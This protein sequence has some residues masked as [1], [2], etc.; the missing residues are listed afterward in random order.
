MLVPLVVGPPHVGSLDSG[1]QP[2]GCK[3]QQAIMAISAT[4]HRFSG[5]PVPLAR[6]CSVLWVGLAP[7]IA[8]AD[9]TWFRIFA[10]LRLD[11]RSTCHVPGNPAADP[12]HAYSSKQSKPNLFDENAQAILLARGGTALSS[13]LCKEYE[14]CL[15]S[16]RAQTQNVPI[17]RKSVLPRAPSDRTR[18]RHAQGSCAAV[19]RSLGIDS[20]DSLSA[21]LEQLLMVRRCINELFGCCCNTSFPVALCRII[22]FWGSI[23]Q[24]HKHHKLSRCKQF[25][26]GKL[27]RSA[28]N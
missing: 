2:K 16:A 8:T 26:N 17:P 19:L 1:S 25:K 20:L 22:S 18:S 6:Q 27:Q 5:L 28:T 14:P 7:C 13:R 4:G 23:H 24:K 3:A 9:F 11:S 15:G 21:L 10:A 12:L